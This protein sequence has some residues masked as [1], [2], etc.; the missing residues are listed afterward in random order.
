MPPETYY[1]SVNH[2]LLAM[3]P[4]DAKRVL[5]VGCG[6]GAL[7]SRHKMIN[8]K[9]E[10]WGVEANWQEAEK[11]IGT[12]DDGNLFRMSIESFIQGGA[13]RKSKFDVIVFGDVLEH[14]QEPPRVLKDLVKWRLAK[15]GH[16]LA[17]VPNIQH[18]SAVVTL[19][20]GDWPSHESGL[21]DDSH[22]RW[23]TKK[24]IVEMFEQAGLSVAKIRPRIFGMDGVEDLVRVMVD[25]RVVPDAKAL[26]EGFSAYQWLIHGV[27]GELP[28]R[29]VLVRG[30][31][32][33]GCCA[34]PRM[35]EPGSFINTVPGFRYSETPTEV[36]KDEKVVVV[37]QR[38]N[39]TKDAIRQHLKDGCLIIGEWD[40]DPW[41]E[42]FKDRLKGLDVEWAIKACHAIQVSTEAIAELVRPI[43]PNVIVF[44]NQIKELRP[45]KKFDAANEVVNV[46]M[47]GQR[48]REDWEEAVKEVNRI[49]ADDPNRYRFV[50]VYDREL[51]DALESPHKTFYPLQPYEKYRE[52]LRSCDVAISTLA[53]NRFNRCKSDI[54]G[55]ECASEGVMLLHGGPL[56]WPT[57]IKL[58]RESF[59]DEGD[60]AR[61]HIVIEHRMLRDHYRSRVEW[62]NG[63]IDRKSELDQQL[64]ERLPE[65]KEVVG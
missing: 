1:S 55:I 58:D 35:T 43:N 24:T 45:A 39:I 16:V 6:T 31:T 65:L 23:F 51:Y 10:Y 11:A 21:F 46:F 9:C 64:F 41:Y 17:C 57:Q 63:L 36:H 26:K 54:T 37:R 62:Y 44:E 61:N 25:A 8:P 19:L 15:G 13:G 30:F 4:P 59:F 34:R 60:T 48:R 14:L 12:I 42:G 3:I 40:D 5:E 2:D 38:F 33:E 47:G 50:V 49:V 22:L 32:A 56:Y 53:D 20:N 29:N 52:L 27:K 28:E 18:I 7:A